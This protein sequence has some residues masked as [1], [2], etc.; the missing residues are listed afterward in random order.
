MGQNSVKQRSVED[1][2]SATF[3]FSLGK[4]CNFVTNLKTITIM[5]YNYI[6]LMLPMLLCIVSLSTSAHNFEVGGIY[7]N[8]TSNEDLTVAVTF[9]GNSYSSYSNEYS[10]QVSIPETVAYNEKTYRVTNI[11]DWAFY[12]CSG[13]TSVTIPN[14][15]TSIG[16]AAFSG[17]SGLTSVTIPNSVK[18]IGEGA[19]SV[20]SGLTSVTIPN[21]VKS[22]GNSAFSGCI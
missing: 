4:L 6:K 18:S 17:C 11:G 1:T 8:I 10:G 9:R 5:K 13:L 3:L 12:G 7:Y 14:G 19:F 21:S 15:V 2:F 22:I 16:G 20:C